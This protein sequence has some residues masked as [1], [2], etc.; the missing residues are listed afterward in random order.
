MK[1][2]VSKTTPEVQKEILCCIWYGELFPFPC[3]VVSPGFWNVKPGPDFV[4][5]EIVIDGR[6][7]RGG[8]TIHLE[9]LSV[10][11]GGEFLPFSEAA[12]A[13]LEEV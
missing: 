3:E 7:I 12:V 11:I 13:L 6:T 8:A 4:E 2:L 9:S 5:A 1:R 10:E